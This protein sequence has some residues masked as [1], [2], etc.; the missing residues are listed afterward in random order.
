VPN[1]GRPPL[2]GAAASVQPCSGLK[3]VPAGARRD[4]L[5]VLTEGSHVR[6]DLIRQFYER[7]ETRNLADVLMDLESDDMLRMRV[8]ELLEE[9]DRSSR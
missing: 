3:R 4:L 6:A 8:I 5:R 2:G 7:E 9:L 1:V